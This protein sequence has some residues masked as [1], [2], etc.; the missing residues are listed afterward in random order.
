MQLVS[1]GCCVVI[2]IRI[3]CS[4]HSFLCLACTGILIYWITFFSVCWWVWLRYSLLLER[5][6]VCLLVMWLLIMRSGLG[7]LQQLC[8]VGLAALDF[9]FSLGCEQMIME[10]THI[11]R[12]G[13]DWVLTDVQDPDEVWVSSS[14]DTSDH[15]A[16]FIDVVLEQPLPAWDIGTKVI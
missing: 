14:V 16:I 9:A 12:G 2:V 7:L 3:R 11:D 5:R 1:V 4:S 10:P 15:N 6:L 13:L 8:T